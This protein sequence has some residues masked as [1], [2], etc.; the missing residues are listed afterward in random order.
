MNR[1]Y[2][3]SNNTDNNYNNQPR[4]YWCHVCRFF[5]TDSELDSRNKICSYCNQ[6]KSYL[7]LLPRTVY[8]KNGFSKREVLQCQDCQKQEAD[9]L[10]IVWSVIPVTR[11]S[12]VYES[13]CQTMREMCLKCKNKKNRSTASLVNYYDAVKAAYRKETSKAADQYN[14]MTI[15]DYLLD[16]GIKDI[17]KID[18]N[19]DA[20]W[21]FTYLLVNTK[22]EERIEVIKRDPDNLL[23]SWIN[24]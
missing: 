22:T 8:Y 11:D 10:N 2:I 17:N 14:P 3:N 16:K 1:I 18:K 9:S 4:E 24:G 13:I 20:L 19:L 15:R 21:P 12:E 23:V 6:H 7:M 5:H